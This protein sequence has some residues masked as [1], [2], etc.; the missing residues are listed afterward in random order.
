MG[1]YGIGPLVAPAILAELGDTRR[2]S[3]SGRPCAALVWTSPFTNPTRAAAPGT[4]SRQGSPVLRWPPW[5]PRSARHDHP[6]QN[7]EHYLQL[8]DRFGANRAAL[9]IARKLLRRA[10]HAARARRRRDRPRHLRP[11]ARPPPPSVIDRGQ[12]PQNCRRHRASMS[13]PERLSGH[14]AHRGI[15]PINDLVAASCL[16]REHRDKARHPRAANVDHELQAVRKA[17][18]QSQP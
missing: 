9:T 11:P 6:L 5:K 15:T 7:H 12:L 3:S 8:K 17:T 16:G 2:L 10:L 14:A 1:H 4:F 18:S 13:D